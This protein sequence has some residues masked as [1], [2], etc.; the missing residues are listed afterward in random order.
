M[1]KDSNLLLGV[2]IL[3]AG[4]SDRMGSSK[5]LLRVGGRTL[6][7]HIL[8]NSFLR[9]AGVCPVVVLGHE[10]QKI[11]DCV[12]LTIPWVENPKYM[13]GRT[14]SVQCGLGDLP[15]EVAGAFIWPVDC[16]FVPASVM[17]ALVE[18]FGGPES[19]CIPSYDFRR[20]HPPL[21]GASYFSEIFSMKEYQS[22]RA[23]YQKYPD[24]IHHVLV[25]TE[26]VLHNLNTPDEFRAI[27]RQFRDIKNTEEN[28]E[29]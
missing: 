12:S 10:A 1:E 19:I 28:P 16:P 2:I 7:E 3:A 8:S 29:S 9:R 25:N 6:L 13:R 15:P 14:T 11:R 21:I 22:L 24:R 23:L 4:R 18:A 5:P 17:E 27:Q 20:G 26:A